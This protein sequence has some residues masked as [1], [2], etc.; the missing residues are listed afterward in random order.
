MLCLYHT[1]K[2]KLKW[3]ENIN[4]FQ[5][6]L[7]LKCMIKIESYLNN[8]ISFIRVVLHIWDF[9]CLRKFNMGFSTIFFSSEV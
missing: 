9:M 3:S 2:D 8:N 7:K 6:R 5:G 4:Y 1:F